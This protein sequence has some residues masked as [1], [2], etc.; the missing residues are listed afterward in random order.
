[1]RPLALCENR[2]P[3][4]E[5]V[6]REHLKRHPTDVA[7][8]RMLAEVAARIGRYA[9]A[10]NLLARCLELAPVSRPRDTTTRRC[11]TG[12]TNRNRR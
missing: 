4:A 10:E 5:G 1:M 2:I 6:L 7:A 8:I 9:D 12:R 11:C 3:E